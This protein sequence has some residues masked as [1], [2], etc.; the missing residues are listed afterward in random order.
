MSSTRIRLILWIIKLDNLWQR[1]DVNQQ[2][3]HE[4][5]TELRRRRLIGVN[6]S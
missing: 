5:N 6:L 1:S 4:L 3:E 2:W